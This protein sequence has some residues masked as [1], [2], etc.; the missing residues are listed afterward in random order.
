MPFSLIA[1]YKSTN[2]TGWNTLVPVPDPIHR[3]EGTKLYVP[4][5]NKLCGIYAIGE[6]TLKGRLR[7]P[8]LMS[9]APFYFSKIKPGSGIDHRVY[10]IDMFERPKTFITTE[11]L[12]VDIYVFDVT[13]PRNLCTLLL[14]GDGVITVPTGEV[15]T[16]EATAKGTADRLWQW[17]NL[18]LEFTDTLAA[19]RYTI[20]G[21]KVNHSDVVAARLVSAKWPHRPGVPGLSDLHYSEV[22]RLT[23]GKMG[24]FGEFEHT[25]PPSIDILPKVSVTDIPLFLDLVKVG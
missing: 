6:Y 5:L 8:S 24:T 10:L 17:N 3:S 1:F 13:A 20:V 21:M 15:W 18:P 19:G 7:A 23:T 25:N 14:F 2:V 4:D 22:E 12:E 16:V 11:P 9:L